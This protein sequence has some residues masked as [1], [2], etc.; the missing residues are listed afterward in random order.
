MKIE[1]ST[2]LVTGA[3]SGIGAALAPM[4]AAR[5]ATVGIVA[6]RKDRLEEVL[7]GAPSTRRRR[8]CGPPTSATSTPPSAWRDEAWDAFGGVDCLVNNAAIPKRTPRAAPHAR[9]GRRG[10]A[11]ELHLAGA[12]DVRAA[13]R[14]L[15][16]DSGCVVNVSSMGGRIGIAHEAAYCA[17]KFALCGW[18]ESMAID[19]HDT[20]VEVKLVLPGPIETE[21]WDLPD[22]DPALY[23]GPFVPAEECAASIVDAI[24]GDGFESYVPPEFPGGLGQAARH[25]RRQDDEPG[26]VHRRD[27][28]DGPPVKALVF[29]VDSGFVPN[30]PPPT[31]RRG[32]PAARSREHADGAPGG[33]RPGAARRPTGS[34][35]A[36][37]L[38]GI[39]GSDTKQVFMDMGGDASDF[40]M[41]AFISFPQVLGHEV[42][43]DVVEVGP[44]VRRARGRPA[45]AAAVLALVRRRAGSR[46][47][48]PRA[49]PATTRCAGTSPTAGSH[50]AST[51]ATRAT[52]RAASP[53]SCP[54]TTRWRSRSPTTSPTRSRCSPT[55]SRSRCTRSPAT[56][57]RR[58][59]ERR[60]GCGCARHLRGRDPAV[61]VPA[62][63]RS[64]RRAHTAAQQ[65]L[66]AQARR[67]RD[68]LGSSTTSARRRRWPSGRAACC[69]S[70]GP[71]SRSRTPASSTSCYDTIA[72]PKTIEL[73][74]RVMRRTRHDLGQ[75]R[76]RAGSVRV[77]A[78]VLQGG[79]DR[80]IER[81]RHRGG[82]RCAQAR[83]R[84]LP[85]LR[86]RR[87]ASTSRRCSRTRSRSTSGAKRSRRSRSSTTPAPSRSPSTSDERR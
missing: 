31:T 35:C 36:R 42:V 7:A 65:A 86:A 10:D 9:G 19:L 64:Q 61:A 39:C 37:A 29:G 28:S 16:R 18:S 77:V 38:T 63:S 57:H 4:L 50:P 51:P 84:A 27:G 75:R 2:I 13:P 87:A 45:R 20:G 6:R 43:A 14:W 40:S 70:R 82:R 60:L 59:Q 33:S 44:E 5:G 11:R 67:P 41:T 17:S 30:R 76:P 81:V 12:D 73:A 46:R 66:A 80:R 3:S 1:G 47:C 85:R 78:V 22:N 48:A 34:C 74:L 58:R 83:D 24:E 21:I 26:R 79:A 23:D 8:G 56:P 49:R 54:R 55:R 15:D 72:S 62:R 69:A 52:R 68:R 25:G 71:G 53:S 32:S